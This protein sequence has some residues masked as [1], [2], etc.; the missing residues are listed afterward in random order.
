MVKKLKLI[1]LKHGKNRL[2]FLIEKH[3]N[4][5]EFLATFLLKCGFE[6][7]LHREY[8]KAENIEIERLE[9]TEENYANENFDIDIVYGH[10][11]IILLVRL[12]DDKYKKRVFDAVY[13]FCELE[14]KHRVVSKK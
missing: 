1:G 7:N 10:K 3:K 12:K 13:E 4:L 8:Y 6:D 9:D 14:R 2:V 5:S 11:T